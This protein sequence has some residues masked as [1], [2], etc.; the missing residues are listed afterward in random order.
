MSRFLS[1]IYNMS[2]GVRREFVYIRYNTAAHVV[3]NTS[4]NGYT[5]EV[6]CN[7]TDLFPGEFSQIHQTI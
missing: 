3:N 1:T 7:L 5:V 6:G 4:I 2:G